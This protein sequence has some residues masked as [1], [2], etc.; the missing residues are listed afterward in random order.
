M[1]MQDFRKTGLM[2]AVTAA[3]GLAGAAAAVA[4]D[5]IPPA[6]QTEAQSADSVSNALYW[7][8]LARSQNCQTCHQGYQIPNDDAHQALQG[9]IVGLEDANYLYSYLQNQWRIGVEMAACDGALRAQLGLPETQGVLITSVSPKEPAETAGIL[10]HDVIVRIAGTDVASADQV[11]NAVN[12]S[13]GAELSIELLRAGKPLTIKVSPLSDNQRIGLNP[14]LTTLR[15]SLGYLKDDRLLRYREV[16]KQKVWIGVEL[17]SMDEVLRSQLQLPPEVGVVVSNV[18]ADSPAAKAELQV[19]DVLVEIESHPLKGLDDLS[20]R[21]QELGEKEV[22]LKIIRGGQSSL[23]RI[24]PEMHTETENPL[25]VWY[26]AEHANQI[27]HT[28]HNGNAQQPWIR[29]WVDSKVIEGYHAPT[30]YDWVTSWDDALVRSAAL[31][32]TQSDPYQRLTDLVTQTEANLQ[33][34]KALAEQLKASL[35]KDPAGSPAPESNPPAP[36]PQDPMK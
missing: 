34:I 30:Q 15:L 22:V 21:L 26:G 9:K 14:D 32:A 28:L 12:A 5:E 35:A 31:S 6:T 24:T 33:E 11:Q 16:L 23:V 25:S 8:V 17:G 20:A 18:V 4:Q 27:L 36:A 10:I 13:Q 19:H 2:L 7:Y 1:R 29:A 3:I